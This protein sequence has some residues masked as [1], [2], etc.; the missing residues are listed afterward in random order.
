[1]PSGRS[2]IGSSVLVSMNEEGFDFGL[3]GV[4]ELF[5]VVGVRVKSFPS[6][7]FFAV[8]VI[9]GRVV[10]GLDVVVPE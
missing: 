6:V 5:A 7:N 2:V 9:R 10:H 4:N 3:D 1:M 8:R